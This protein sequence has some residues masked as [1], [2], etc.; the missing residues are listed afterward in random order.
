MTFNEFF[1]KCCFDKWQTKTESLHATSQNPA[2]YRFKEY[3]L[4]EVSGHVLI[5]LPALNLDNRPFIHLPCM[6]SIEHPAD[7]HQADKEHARPVEIGRGYLHAIWPETPEERPDCV[8]EGGDVDWEAEL[9]QCP[10]GVWQRLAA[11]ALEGHAANGDE[12]G[13]HEGDRGEGEDGVEGDGAADVDQ[14][15]DDREGA[16]ENDAVHGDVPG[17]V[18]LREYC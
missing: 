13:G 4:S 14:G 7:T 2:L 1:L 5:E 18:D 10:A 15:H 12:V 11:Q 8:D 16:G 9:A 6:H 17:F 3:L